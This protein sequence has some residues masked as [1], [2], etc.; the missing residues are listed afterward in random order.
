M[1]KI[2]LENK[3]L[4]ILTVLLIAVVLYRA[5]NEFYDIAWGTGSWQ[6]K[7]SRTWAVLYYSFTA[8]CIIS[9]SLIAL[10]TWNKKLFAPVEK[11]IIALRERMQIFRWLLW[12]AILAAPVWFF[13]YT[14]WGFAFD[15]PFIRI[16]IWII[17]V[18][19][20]TVLSSRR[21]Q[22]TGWNEFLAS[23][24]LTASAFSIAA[25]LKYV[26]DYPFS[27]GWSEGNR[28]WD[29][30]VL[31]GRDLYIYPADKNIPVFLDFGRNL[32]GGLPFI[33]PG[34]TIA[35]ERLWVGLTLI[36]PYLLLG[37]A[38]FRANA[39]NKVTWLLLVLWTFLFLK[40]GPIHAPLVL[41]AAAVALA[42]NAPLWYAIP[43]MLG[44]GYFVEA[45]RFTWV[46][47]PFIWIV[48]LEFASTAFASLSDRKIVS[49]MW[50]RS[51]ILGVAGLL[52]AFALPSMFGSAGAIFSSTAPAIILP[53]PTTGA[54][55]P[56]TAATTPLPASTTAVAQPALEVTPV[57]APVATAQPELPPYLQLVV[58]LVED[59]PLLWYRLLPNS[60]FTNGIILAL[61]LAI[62]PLTI[63]L[64][65]LLTAKIWS[66]S[67]LQKLSLILPL[68]AF[69]AVGLVA[70]TKIG[71]GGDLHNMDMFLIG[72]F[73]VGAIAWQNGGREWIQNGAAIPALIKIV[74]VALIINSSIGPLFEMRSYTLG[75]DVSWLK[76]L[77]DAPSEL[78]LEML[79]TPADVDSAIQTIQEEADKA[80]SQGEILF[81]DQRQL[82]TFGYVK[83]IPLVA[84]Y[85][86]KVLM[87]QAMSSNS[88]YFQGYY[89]DLAAKRFSLII[90]EPLHTPVKDSTYEFGEENNAWVEWVS[91]PTLCYYEPVETLKTVRM[92][93]LVP[94]EGDVDC[95]AELP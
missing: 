93:L 48:M 36:I 41:G 22:L 29:Y 10:F 90:T 89:A 94:K 57:P 60:T 58:R 19:L 63:V 65:Y 69:L 75:E 84:E 7:F 3:F 50:R 82:L 56:V 45:S 23:L 17:I 28:L 39:K 1:N 64:I 31:F 78:S 34:V 40:Q 87:N 13:Q 86:K 92:Q 24:I 37:L 14:A 77:T 2:T 95:S 44:A 85:E 32:I 8:L 74:I 25:S 91:G 83:G 5:S 72:M 67:I 18:C 26:N 49:S 35:M 79:P 33:F 80:K 81:I 21:D 20:L 11:W 70:S 51:I 73:F 68:L 16:L 62:T 71:G 15:K 46:F 66:L 30:S 38:L 9:F 76:T 59:Q 55:S 53:T 52:G 54:S 47:A 43:L 61:L 27:F 42:W 4:K 12:L 88:G 6:G